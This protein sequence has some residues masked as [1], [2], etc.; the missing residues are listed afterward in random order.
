MAKS[1]TDL[2]E[3]LANVRYELD[4]MR[5]NLLRAREASEKGSQL[6][7][8]SHYESWAIHARNL[9][10]FLNSDDD[11]NTNYRAQDYVPG[12][13]CKK[14]NDTV[15]T[16]QRLDPEVFHMGTKRPKTVDKQV[17]IADINVFTEWVEDAFEDFLT[18]VRTGPH[19]SGWREPSMPRNARVT[20]KKFA[21]TSNHLTTSNHI[22]V[23]SSASVGEFKITSFPAMGT[24]RPN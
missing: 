16:L 9:Y 14:S 3:N 19:S 15:R 13:S 1:E 6:G 10:K 5:F 23:S 7:Y 21:S 20:Y 18:K 11:K 4:M 8:N 12:F 17:Q 2:I 22:H 24:R